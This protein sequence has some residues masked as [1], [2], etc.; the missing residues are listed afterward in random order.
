[1]KSKRKNIKLIVWLILLLVVGVAAAIVFSAKIYVITDGE[2]TGDD[3]FF[4]VEF[5]GSDRYTDEELEDIFF[6]EGKSRGVARFVLNNL[7]SEKLDIPFVETYDMEMKSPGK[8]V[9]TLYDKSVVGYI[10]YMSNNI[11]FDKDGIVVESSSVELENVPLITGMSFDYVVLHEKLPA[12]NENIFPLLLDLTQ[13]CTKYNIKTD[14]INIVGNTKIQMYVENVR[15]DLGDGSMLN[16]K[17]LDLY[18]MS[19]QLKDVSGVLNMEEYDSE[20]KGYILKK[21]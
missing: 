6:G 4:S 21:N 1:M 13:L 11:Y 14:K 16:E 3:H 18:D 7:F 17:M 8:F 10:K 20:D 2:G 19:E 15:V 12:E 5:K 9:I